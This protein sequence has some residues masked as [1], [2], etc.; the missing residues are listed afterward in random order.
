MG[1]S[2]DMDTGIGSLAGAPLRSVGIV[3]AVI[4]GVIH[5]YLGVSFID[6]PLGLSFLVAAVGFG[7]GIVGV[8]YDY[9][10]T[11]LYVLGIPFVAGQIVVWYVVNAPDFGT[12]GYVDKAV[13]AVLIV[14]LVLLYRRAA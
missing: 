5:L 12:L 7:I 6:S 2:T 9:R 4:T 10:R 8:L 14:V 1:T 13:Q 11:L 3:L